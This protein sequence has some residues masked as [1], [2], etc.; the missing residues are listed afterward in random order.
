MLTYL[1][2]CPVE[3]GLNDAQVAQLLEAHLPRTISRLRRS[4]K[5][6][7]IILISAD[8]LEVLGAL[9][10]AD[11]GCPVFLASLSPFSLE[12]SP[13]VMDFN[14]ARQALA[15]LDHA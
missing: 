8:L 11:L 5:P 4:F 10:N 12:G 13:T 6:R 15:G 7:R 14:S 9:Q 1:L 2:E 3:P